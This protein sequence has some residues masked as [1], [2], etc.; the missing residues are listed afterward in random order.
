MRIFLAFILLMSARQ[1]L[2][3]KKSFLNFSLAF[4]LSLL[5][6]SCLKSSF[7]IL[8][9]KFII[10]CY[11]FSILK[12]GKM[13]FEKVLK[14]LLSVALI[15]GIFLACS[16]E[17][18]DE[19]NNISSVK[20]QMDEENLSFSLKMFDGGSMAVK[21]E[22]GHLSFDNA[23]KATLFV[24][25]TTWC[26]PCLGEIP[27]L[28]KI[29]EKYKEN[30]NIIGVLLEDKD[31][32]GLEN[33]TLKHKINYQI[34]NGEENYLFARVLG[35]VSGVPMMFLYGKGGMLIKQY[36]GLVPSEMLEIDIAKVL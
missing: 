16:S 24:F 35:G 27:H 13:M 17:K 29:Q 32:E 21:K 5:F 11:N 14:N 26:M 8:S 22:A 10:P 20:E 23:N 36:L 6:C 15:A 9:L 33:F 18:Q 25:F 2:R 19:D 30:F 3:I 28:N 4:C 31:K 12:R 1:S 7:C 34:A